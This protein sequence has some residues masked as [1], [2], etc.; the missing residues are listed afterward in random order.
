[1]MKTEDTL[2]VAQIGTKHGHANGVYRVMEEH[3]GVEVVGCF[4]PDS[5]RRKFCEDSIDWD[6]VDWLDSIDDI[7]GDDEIIAVASEGANRES[8]AHTEAIVA[9]GKHCFYDKPAGDDFHRFLRVIENAHTQGL[10]V[11]LGYMFRKHDGFM[12]IADWARSGFLGHVFQIRAHMS[13]WLP[14]MSR[15]GQFTDRQGL[16]YHRGGVLFD[17][18]GHV[19]DQIVWILGRPQRVTPFLQNAT[20]ETR[21]FMDNTLAVMEYPNALATVDIA[22]MEP[23]PMARRFEVYGTEGSAI[24]EPFEPAEQLRLCLTRGKEGYSEGVTMID[25]E[26]RRRYVDTFAAFVATIKGEA[27]SLR[28]LEHELLVQET[29]MRCT[30]GLASG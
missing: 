5:E 10:E 13:T 30:G 28:S 27:P 14:E 26:D 20:S 21:D 15:G 3:P 9:A 4:E 16:S 6:G 1:M 18:G 29:L 12:R 11:T 25:L 2:K 19:L 17:L 7:L 24:M 22:A 23:R 8:L